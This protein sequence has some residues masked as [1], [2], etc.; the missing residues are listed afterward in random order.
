[1]KQEIRK[2]I[3]EKIAPFLKKIDQL[4]EK[5]SEKVLSAFQE[6]GIATTD[7]IGT[8]GYGYQDEGRDK[9]EEVYAKVLGA[10]DALVRS[11]F[12]SGSHALT[13]ALLRFFVQE[14]FF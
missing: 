10:E 13:V 3:E 14:L 5:Q 12:I 7:F 8:T 1:M 2:K 4:E 11:Q 6:V 9:I